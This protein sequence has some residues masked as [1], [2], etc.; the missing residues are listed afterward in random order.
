MVR[1]HYRPPFGCLT[2]YTVYVLK[3]LKNGKR[4][5]GMTSKT[6]LERMDWHRWGLT[7]WTRQNGPFRF[8]Y[9]E[10]YDT[11]A[12]AMLREKYFKTGQGRRT[13]ESLLMNKER[14]V[15]AKKLGGPA[16][17]YGGG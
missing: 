9:S 6:V 5:V 3:S 11:K 7:A 13:L 14:S 1:A 12:R 4:Y 16:M 15:S 17:N 8:L 2:I 10:E